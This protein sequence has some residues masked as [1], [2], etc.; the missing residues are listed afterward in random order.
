MINQII[1]KFK[2]DG[3]FSVINAIIEYPFNI[4]KRKAYKR[5]LRL[6]NMSEKFTEIYKNISKL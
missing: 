3:L 4:S 5:M 1:D 2:R 6:D